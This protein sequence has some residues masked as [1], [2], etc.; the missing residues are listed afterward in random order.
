MPG[1]FTAF[2]AEYVGLKG[3]QPP[4]GRPLEVKFA[5]FI[6][7]S[8]LLAHLNTGLKSVERR[9]MLFINL[10]ARRAST[11]I[12]IFKLEAIG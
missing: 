3:D 4:T 1:K 6:K 9:S 8:S 2:Q 10:I 5:A 12:V 7:P 11:F